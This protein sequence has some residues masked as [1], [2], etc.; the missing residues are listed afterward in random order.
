M[1]SINDCSACR[2]AG[3]ALSYVPASADAVADFYTTDKTVDRH[4]WR[5]E[6]WRRVS[7]SLHASLADHM[8][9]NIPGKPTWV[10]TGNAR[11]RWRAL[12][13][14]YRE[15]GGPGRHDNRRGVCRHQSLSPLLRKK[16]GYDSAKLQ[17]I[18]S[19]TA[20]QAS[21]LVAWKTSS[22]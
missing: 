21:V 3:L 2:L 16:V 8:A 19:V 4:F 15:C 6:R 17:W 9:G 22:G 10:V 13:Q 11:C 7:P 5:R 1:R 18:G 12:D 14:V 20:A